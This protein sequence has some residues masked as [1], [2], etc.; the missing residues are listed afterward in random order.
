MRL[1]AVA[2]LTPPSRGRP[3]SG[4]PLTSN[5]RCEGRR[6]V[7]RHHMSVPLR[8]INRRWSA[9]FAGVAV[10]RPGSCHCQRRHGQSS[11]GRQGKVCSP[12]LPSFSVPSFERRVQGGRWSFTGRRGTITVQMQHVSAPVIH[13]PQLRSTRSSRSSPHCHGGCRCVAPNPFVKGTS[14]KRAAPYVER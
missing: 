5:V 7:L 9:R 4:P 14:R 2:G 11:K 10:G 3:A 13:L 8:S 12:G 6:S 1:V